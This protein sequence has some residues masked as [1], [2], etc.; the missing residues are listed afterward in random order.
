M[1]F[2]Q[3]KKARKIGGSYQA[4]GWIVATF[5]TLEGEVRVVFQFD[6]FPMLHIFRQ[7]QVEEIK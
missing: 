2:A 7:H 3:P 1:E 4:E 6:A 5:Q